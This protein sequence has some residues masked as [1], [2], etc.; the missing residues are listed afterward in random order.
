MLAS[1][2]VYIL[3]AFHFIICTINAM[4]RPCPEKLPEKLI[5]GYC[6]WG[7]A[8]EKILTAVRQGVNV[9]IWFSINLVTD[10][11]SGSASVEDSPGPNMNEVANIIDTIKS[12]GIQCVHLISIGGW[13]SPHPTIEHSAEEVFAAMQEWNEKL[14]FGGFDGF[15]WDVEGNDD[16]TSQYNTFKTQTLH[17]I[18]RISVLAKQSGYIVAMAPA[19]SYLDPTTSVFSLSLQFNHSEWKA[20]ETNTVLD[21][22]YHG[23]NSYAPLLAKYGVTDTGIPTFDF[24]T[25]QLYEGHSHAQWNILKQGITPAEHIVSLVTALHSGWTVDFDLCPPMQMPSQTVSLPATR[26]VIGLANAWAG[27][28]DDKFLLLYPDDIAKVYE[29]LINSSLYIRGFAFWNIKDEGL[30]QKNRRE[31]EPVWMASALKN[32]LHSV[33]APNSG[34]L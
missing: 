13:N 27:A 7:Q 33:N 17:L 6:N 5:I 22:P 10:S 25:L 16:P 18:G 23:R 15:D 24:V 19:E 12:E 2:R 14:P 32:V 29:S 4:Q 9:V 28:D 34:E 11:A 1:H 31:D 30:V 26:L 21:F 20:T 8:D 3:L